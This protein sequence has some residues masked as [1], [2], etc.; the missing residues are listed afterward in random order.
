ML[1]N[2]KICILPEIKKK[3]KHCIKIKIQ[4]IIFNGND[5]NFICYIKI[6]LYLK[7]EKKKK[8][9]GLAYLKIKIWRPN[10]LHIESNQT[11]ATGN[12]RIYLTRQ[13]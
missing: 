10:Y 11:I 2:Q 9:H 13:Q 1:F 8:N 3:K 12:L 5:K 4:L 7:L 6:T